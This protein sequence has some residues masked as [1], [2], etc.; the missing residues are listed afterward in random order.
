MSVSPGLYVLGTPIGNLGDISRRC[1]E[2]LAA[3]QTVIAEDTRRTRQL[4]SHLGLVGKQL[5]RVDANASVNDVER[6]AQSL[7]DGGVAAL[8][9]DAGMPSVSDPGAA[10][11]TR[12]RQLE[13]PVCVVPGPSAVTTAVAAAGFAEGG[14]WFAGFLPRKG[15]KR[16]ERLRQIADFED[17]VVLF[18][19]AN[20]MT[21]T[22]GDFLEF[23]P[24]RELCVARELTKQ[25]EEVEVRTVTRWASET[26]QWLGEV[27]LV[28]GPV[29][30]VAPQP[31]AQE[32]VDALIQRRLERGETA[33]AVADALAPLLKISR[34]AIYQRALEL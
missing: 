25:Y 2:T 27:T 24:Q 10:V 33:R 34:R 14:F 1:V 21:G 20:R 29:V 19:A 3:A 9:T 32:D 16:R 12:C 31:C 22:L 7:V 23:M 28:L 4:L 17:A 30:A 5:V 11:V 18:E 15:E 8:V 13:I 26:R 6:I